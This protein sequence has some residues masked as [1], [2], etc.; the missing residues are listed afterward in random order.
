MPAQ[1]SKPPKP[2]ISPEFARRLARLAPESMARAVVL[3]D[4]GRA[5]AAAPGRSSKPTRKTI[6]EA[7]QAS[8][9]M[10]LVEVDRVLERS[11][12][13]RLAAGPDLLGSIPVEAPASA[14]LALARSEQVRAIL[15][16]QPMSLMRDPDR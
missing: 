3:L 7:I 14:L 11:G 16:D 4:T 8:A 9:A 6:S 5:P 1:S 15:E 12:G 13:R 2:K 10:A